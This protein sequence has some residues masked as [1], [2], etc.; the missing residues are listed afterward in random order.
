MAE[1]G[2]FLG[3]FAWIVMLSWSAFS[4]ATTT[5]YYRWAAACG[6]QSFLL[7]LSA[8]GERWDGMGWDGM[9]CDWHLII[10]K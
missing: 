3:N 2:C 7:E 8:R 1:Q 9:G 10:I 6:A 5:T 4:F